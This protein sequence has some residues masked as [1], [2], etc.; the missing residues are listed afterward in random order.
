[1]TT[2]QRELPQGFTWRELK[3]IN[4]RVPMP[5]AW[6]FMHQ[7]SGETSAYFMTKESIQKDGMFKTGFS[8][9]AI[10]NAG[11]RMGRPAAE[12]AEKLMRSLPLHPVSEVIKIDDEPLYLYRRDFVSLDIQTAPIPQISGE[13]KLQVVPPTRF[14]VQAVG[15]AATD[16][17]YIAQFECPTMDWP[18]NQEIARTMIENVALDKS[19]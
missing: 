6:F 1:M 9:N 10:R 13:V 16:T 12:I 19:I 4:A 15:N 14:S 11:K 7:K 2:E 5:E 8:L 3:E 17:L 18:Q